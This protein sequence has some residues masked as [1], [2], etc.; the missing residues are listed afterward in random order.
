MVLL[1]TEEPGIETSYL[2]YTYNYTPVWQ[3]SKVNYKLGECSTLWGEREQVAQWFG[4]VAAWVWARS[5]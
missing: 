1:A 3:G 4:N 5:K 2:C